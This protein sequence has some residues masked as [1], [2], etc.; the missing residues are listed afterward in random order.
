M[1]LENDDI[2]FVDTEFHENEKHISHVES[3]HEEHVLHTKSGHE[4]RL[5]LEPEV[6]A[7]IAEEKGLV[8]HA[9]L[10]AALIA[11]LKES[12]KDNP[13]TGGKP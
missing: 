9:T 8:L 12:K 13:R 4:E 6:R 2:L 10:P 11:A 3:E 1:E 5:T 7:T